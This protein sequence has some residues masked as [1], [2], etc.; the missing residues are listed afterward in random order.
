MLKFLTEFEQL[1]ATGVST[2]LIGKE[3]LVSVYGTRLGKTKF[4]TLLGFIIDSDINFAI[5]YYGCI[6]KSNGLIRQ[7]LQDKKDFKPG[8][9]YKV[10]STV[11]HFPSIKI[12]QIAELNSDFLSS[13]MQLKKTILQKRGF[14][15]SL[16]TRT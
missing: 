11:V 16:S 3:E 8:Q 14:R 12:E 15:C 5:D 13:F 9:L 10:F 1:I 6:K 2:G 4:G 7:I